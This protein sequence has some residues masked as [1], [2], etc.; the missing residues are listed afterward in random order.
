M[1]TM[2]KSKKPVLD[3]YLILLI[4]TQF[5]FL[6]ISERRELVDTQMI[7]WEQI[8][9]SRSYLTH[10]SSNVKKDILLASYPKRD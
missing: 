2:V 3:G 10:S 4:T 9:P 8:S 6:N 1:G 5:R 7:P